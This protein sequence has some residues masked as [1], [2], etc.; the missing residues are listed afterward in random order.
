MENKAHTMAHLSS[1]H[2]NLPSSNNQQS[3]S[4]FRNASPKVTTTTK[5]KSGHHL[6]SAAGAGSSHSKKTPN[7]N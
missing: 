4:Y 1:G 2:L 7:S 3:L 5:A 6:Y